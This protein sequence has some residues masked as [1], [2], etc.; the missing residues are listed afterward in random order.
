MA[1]PGVG[2]KF[3][4]VNLNKSY[5]QPPSSL[6]NAT[7]SRVRPGSHHA[8]GGMV[9]LSKP[10]NSIV[11]AQ[12]SGPRLSVPPPLNLPSLRKEHERFDASL[13]GGGSAGV[14]SSSSGSRPTSSGM[15]WTKP[16]P[17]ILL[18]KNGSGDH[19]L[20]G[21]L[22][23]GIEAIDGG[24]MPSYSADNA[25][26]GS[27]VYMPPS[28][29]LGTAEPPVVGS[30][31]EFT[32]VEKAVVLRGEDFPSLQATLPAASGTAQK[33]RYILHEKQ[34]QK[35]KQKMSEETLGGQTDSSYMR[36]QLHMRTQMQSSR[37]TVG[38]GSKNNG[39]IHGS[40]SSST[41]EQL[42][43]HDKYFPGPLPLIQ[44][45][46]TSDWADDERDTRH[47]L[48]DRD[49]EQ[50]FSR[51]EAFRDREFD[52]HR[53]SVLPR[54]SVHDFSEGRGLCQDEAAKMSSRGEPYGKDVR[55]PS[56]EDQDVNSW[57]AS[58]LPKDGFSA[59]EAGIDRNGVGARSFTL[60]REINKENKYNQLP[61]GDN[62]RD[63]FSSGVMGTQDLRFGRKD[64]AYGQGGRQ[65]FSHIAVPFSGRGGEQNVRDRHGGGISNRYRGDMFQ[66]NSMP[67]NSFSLG[68]K[69][70]PVNDPI[71]DFGREKRS[72]ST[73]RKPYQEDPFLKDFGIG[74]GFDVRD[75]F[76]SSL[77]GVFR[78]KKDI[79]KQTNFHDPVRESFEAE[80]ERVQKMQEQERQRI[81]EEQARAL[82]QARKEE[83]ERERFAREEEEKQRR[84]EE[85]AR[86]AAWR[87]EQERLE[88]ARRAEEQR[89]AREEERR[90][91]LLEEERRKE[92]AKLKLLELEARIARRQDEDVK[93]DKFPAPI[94]DGRMPGVVKE[95][96]V[97]RSADVGDWEDGNRMVERITT[98]ASS[99]S[100]SL[101]RSSEMGS[102]PQ[103]SRDGN[104]IL[105][106]RGKPPGS[107]RRNVFE[108]E[109]ISTFVLHDQ[110]NAYRS[111][112]R[113]AFGSGRSYPR[114]E[115]YGGPGVMSART[116]SRGIT[117]PHMFDDFSH[118]RGHRWNLP[119]DGVQYSRNSEIEPEFYENLT[120]K[121]TDMVW[122]QGR[123][124]GNP[125][126][127]YPERLYQNEVEGFSSFGRS[128]HSVRQP[129]VLPPPSLVSMH[130]SSFGGESEHPSSSA[131]LDSEMSYH[132]LPRRSEP[133][134]QR[135]Y[136]GSYQEKFEQPRLTDARQEKIVCEEP[137]VEKTTT[138]RCDSQS[139]LSV[140]SPPNS[141]TH[142]SH[143]DLDEAGDSPDLTIAAKGEV[144]P[145]SDNENV[146][147]VKEDRNM[148][149]MTASY[150]VSPG[151]DEEWATGND[152]QEQE[153]YD[154]EEDGYQEED[155]VHE[156]DDE[157]I[158]L[159]QGFEELHLEEHC[160]MAKMG[161]LVLGFNEGVEVGMPSEDES[162]KN[163]GN[164]E[165]ST[166]IQ[167]VSISI[168]EDTRSLDG[169][170]G[171]SQMLHPENSS[172]DMS[173]ENS[174][175]TIQECENAL[176]DVVLQP[177]NSPHS[178]ATTSIYLQG[179]MDDSS[180]SSLSAQQPVASSVPLPSPSVQS[181]MS[182]VS[183]VP[184][185]GDVPVQLQFGLFS[186]PSLIP[187]PVPAIQIGSIQ[188]PLHLHPP[189]GPS[190]TQMHP[191]QP[192]MFQ[193]GQLRYTSPISQGILPLSPQSL[194]F[195][196]PTVQ[197]H[198]SLNQNQGGLLHS[199]AG[200]GTSS[201]NN[202]VEDKMP[203]VLND[204]QSATAHDLFTKENGCKDMNN[205]SA[206]ENANNELLTSPN[207]TGSSV[208]GEKKNGFV[209]QDQDVKKYRAIA[210]N[211]ES[212]LQPDSIASQLVPSKRALG[213]PKAAGLVTGGTK[214][215][216]FIYTVKNSGSRSSFPNSESVSTD[217]SGFPRRIRRNIRRTE[218]RVRENVDRKQIEGLVSSS[219]GLDEKSNLNGRVS[220]S[221]AGSGIKKDAILVKPSKQ[222]VDSE[223]T[224]SHSSSFHVVDSVSKM[225]K[226]LGKE[227][228]AKGFT[229]SLGISHSGEG[230]VK[231]NSSLEEGVDAP[232]QSGVVRVFKQPGIEAPSDEDDFIEVR[233]KRQMLNDRREQREKE[234]KAKSRALKAPRKLCSASQQSIMVSTNSNRTPTSLDGEA[235]RNIHSDSV[236]TDGRAL[237]NVG[238]STGFATTIMSQSLPPIGTPAMNSDSPADIRSHNIKSLQAG[239]IPI[240]S[241]GG[242]NLGLGLSFENKNT[243]M[244]NVQTSLGSWG[245]ALINQQVMALTQTQLDEAMKPTRFD[246]HVAS[247]G[248]HTNTVIEPSKSSPSLLTQDKSFS[249]SASPLNSLLAGEKIQF[250]AVTS[251]TI[252]PPPGG[253]TVLS[254]FGPT[255]SC[256]SDVPI[257]HNLSA[258]E[259][260]CGLFFKKEKHSNE[261]CVH[262]E[263]PESEAEAAA[264]AIAVA[265]I[266]SDE[267]VG[268][269]LGACSVSV[270]DTKSFGSAEIGGV[271]GYQQLSNQSRGEESLAVSL[272]ADLSVETPSLSLW[273]PLPSPQNSSSQMLSHFPAASPSHFPCYEMNPML[274]PPIFAFGPHDESVGSQSQ[275]QKSSTPSSGPLGAWQQ[276]HSGVD[277]FYGPPAGFTGPFISPPGGIPG[278][279]GPP[280]MVVYNHFA[281]VN[282]FGQ[283]GLSF[284]GT[285]YIPSGKQPDWKH[286][287]A[288]STMGV[289]EGDI[290]NLNVVSAQRNSPS[291]PTIQ[292]LAPGSPL[293]PMASPL[294]MFDMSPFQSSSDMSVQARWSHVP[295]SPLH[296]VSLPMPLQQQT[297]A[298]LPA[299][300]NHGLAVEQS[301]SGN[302]FHEPRS[303]APPDSSRSFPV[304]NDATAS[305]LPDELGLVEQSNS[306]TT[307]VSSGRP[308][309]FNSPN[310]NVKA[311]TVVTKSTSR[312]A[313]ANAS[314]S[315]SVNSSS[316]NNSQS[317]NSVFKTQSS[318]QT[319]S[320][321]QYIHPTGY[322]D[323]R[324]GGVS[325]KDS[326]GSEWSHRRI[327][328]QGRNQSSG[329]DK[330]FASSKM[331]QIYVAKSSISGSSA[332]V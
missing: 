44:L 16:A 210:N 277:S 204:N 293:L 234:I 231:Q 208:I 228:P 307:R 327:G 158:E 297:E 96:D 83:E 89:M 224:A 55:T 295:P 282:Q 30:A 149:M 319:S 104:S 270:S 272:P 21:T 37:L 236:A 160:T 139:S 131:F 26:K 142:L 299:Q 250:G 232:L 106:D 260:D 301:S 192:P 200:Q 244:D 189:V 311:Q 255:G 237:A 251:P 239:S 84:L 314:D 309:S 66:T 47:G 152:L 93:N 302:R 85:E 276:C 81:V 62:A 181:V 290:N 225:E 129:H 28:A 13:A 278:V 303:S 201:Q 92:A 202:I 222:M 163:S 61:F 218:F 90:R 103:S 173:M 17:S 121:F 116:S 135:G 2:T 161:Q 38:S 73:S 206:R 159:A 275:A 111:P 188:M 304:A 147:S 289:S 258:A 217:S 126:M 41:A 113:D 326:S 20:L 136:D 48:P 99:D 268:N 249:S 254:G 273:P 172:V 1:N 49:K 29:R 288:S 27:S 120:D 128:R 238:M 306:S 82:E 94:G 54:A 123:S 198:Y 69:G 125:H 151:E 102:R 42:H 5:G 124:R 127:P 261:S 71:L 219:N 300:F 15:G 298:A 11:G 110:E 77:V 101:N 162:E 316:S 31:R 88:A 57:R 148:N 292:H 195:V 279:Q 133:I 91:I 253:C 332:A 115:F 117:E 67:K 291:M 59:R 143:D 33:Q 281:P 132:H 141:P 229:S 186:G 235:A 156:G 223:S 18:E 284:M 294:A 95:K 194:S 216:K 145:L 50:C 140:S 323:Q 286:N 154:E 241:S 169:F 119:G 308:A 296:S 98:S 97:S 287:P 155:E 138:P 137:K 266:S 144:K 6:G 262:L 87:A 39:V 114:K 203:S 211:K 107:W 233:S 271:A 75:P 68:V 112:R 313:V 51:S 14:G 86:E 199:Q 325:Q 315:V 34:M 72:F 171:N 3:V 269:G 329:T 150:S 52:M 118:P 9:V 60:N 7:T 58:P 214:G 176:Q 174:S 108:N 220:S 310:G 45:N 146:A 53:G 43:K 40:G 22:V 32:P 205:S 164:G 213:G 328:F 180:C 215:R 65:N 8:G 207:Q 191:S 242:S 187:S 221:A 312:N 134:M 166:S 240:I 183:T 321:Q 197:A 318:Q 19:S 4:S 265:A 157:N 122:G 196:Q 283:V 190:L 320:T 247:I 46:H 245:N 248:D 267:I 153:E 331:K 80:L 25:S 170:I 243:V 100:S 78:R 230:N 324:G 305:Q 263:D 165:N 317:M 182:N 130:K 193:F 257:D 109:N 23:G 226:V 63:S 185:Q 175:I 322:S 330:S 259:S 105:L 184:S 12:K 252:L 177:G 79:H 280:H 209:S 168:A 10:R 212:H 285:T 178:V 167:Q 70:L 264:S 36:P 256:R 64:L 35:H 74:P 56:R 227:V 179:S 246:T 274:G 76:S 24:D